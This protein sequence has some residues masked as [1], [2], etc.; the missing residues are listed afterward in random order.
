MRWQQT[1]F[2]FKG[3][4]LGM[5]FF[6]GLVLLAALLLQFSKGTTFFRPTYTIYLRA[7]NVGGLKMRA[8]VLMAG[9]GSSPKLEA[10]V[11]NQ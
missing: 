5:L 7:A 11:T 1:E 10:N 6:V 2:I 8:S 3:I 4:Y 9:F